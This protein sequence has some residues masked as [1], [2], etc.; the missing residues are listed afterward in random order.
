MTR[1]KMAELTSGVG[2]LVLIAASVL[3]P[4][5]GELLNGLAIGVVSH[6]IANDDYYFF[7]GAVPTSTVL[8]ISMLASPVPSA[9]R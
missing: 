9:T 2:A 5:L 4:P 3:S 8:A 7:A 1:L 6:V